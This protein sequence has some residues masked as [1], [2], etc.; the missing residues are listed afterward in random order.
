[1]DELSI[2]LPDST[3]PLIIEAHVLT[4]FTEARQLNASDKETGG[5]LLARVSKEE[6]RILEAT[7]AEKNA[8]ISRFLFQPNLKQKRRIVQ[9]AFKDG[10]HFIGEWHTHPEKDPS[11]SGLDRYS[12]T[13]SFRRS[14]HELDCFVMI[15]VGNRKDKLSLS[16]TLHSQEGLTE[17]AAPKLVLIEA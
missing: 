14:K 13:D 17:I 7:K 3:Q 9:E 4:T 5:L 11:P 6:V 8:S 10:L 2:V 15:I 12:M 16:I 1:M